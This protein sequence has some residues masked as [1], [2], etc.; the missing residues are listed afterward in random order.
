MKFFKL[1]VFDIDGT[2][3]RSKSAIDTEMAELICQLLDKYKVAIISGANYEQFKWQIL[4]HLSC[5]SDK[6][7]DLYILPVDGTV[8]CKD[9]DAWVCD[10]D[11]PLSIEEKELIKKSFENIFE[12]SGLETPKKIY[13]ELVEDRGAQFN[14]SALGQNAPVELKEKWDPDNKKRERII[15]VL[16]SVLPGLSLH[17]G[18]TTSIEVTKSNIDKA[19]GLKKLI[20]RIGI[21]KEEILYLGDHLLDG[22]NDA[23]ALTLGIECRSVKGPEETKKEILELLKYK[24]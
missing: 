19:Y 13:G 2:L 4:E 16:K 6:M 10:S 22:G 7:R 3:T 20:R 11:T 5:S 8:F 17:I 14:F 23:P 24:S 1:I 12:R 15:G 21:A 18:G 9:E